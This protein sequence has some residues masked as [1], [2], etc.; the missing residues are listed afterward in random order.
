M[1]R[2]PDRAGYT[3]V[4][5]LALGLTAAL[6]LAACGGAEGDAAESGG[7]GSG[8]TV[9]FGYI[10]DFNGAS[11]LAV[12]EDQ[13]LWEEAGLDV[14]TPVFNDGPTQIQALETG[15]LDFG[16]IGPGA[17]WMPLSGQAKIV[18]INTI[19][20]ADRV[21]ALPDSG[22][23]SIGDLKGKRVG[24][25][26]GTSGEMILNLALQEAG[27]SKDDVELLDMAPDVLVQALSTGQVDAAG[28]WY[29][30][31]DTVKEQV[32]GLVELAE[33]S[34]FTGQINFPTAFVGGPNVDTEDPEAT[35]KVLSVL[36][37]ANDYRAENVK[38][39][40]ELTADMLDQPVEN[41]EVDAGNSKLL[42]TEE[43]DVAT[44]D[45]TIEGWLTGLAEYFESTDQLGGGADPAAVYTGDLWTGASAR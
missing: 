36:R 1:A 34:D 26:F 27:M 44:E 32:P 22:I 20:T 38:E 11:L 31:L 41:V 12:A 45:G 4:A 39:T 24:V 3:R 6:S 10:G 8:D 2:T 15:N 29:P 37:E 5:A 33:N 23:A 14:E 40:V 42:T 16:Y 13:G 43:L 28:F 35:K 30:Y 7:T 25:P 9:Q 18:A 17:M 21:V 19:G